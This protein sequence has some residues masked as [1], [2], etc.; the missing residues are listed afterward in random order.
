KISK[1]PILNSQLLNGRIAMIES[2]IE[3]LKNAIKDQ[4]IGDPVWATTAL[5]GQVLFGGRFVIQW[6]VSEYKKKSLVPVSFWYL[7]IGGSL[8]LLAYS[9]HIKNPIFMLSF[10]LNT[11]IYVRNL[12]LLYL[13]ARRMKTILPS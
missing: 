10:S 11:L 5:V 12:H 6:L 13:E 4:I 9:I 7:S 8:L 2:A 1:F 3:F